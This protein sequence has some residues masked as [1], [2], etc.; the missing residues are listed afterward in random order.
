M[1]KQYYLTGLFLLS[2][3]ILNITFIFTVASGEDDGDG[4]DDDFEEKNKRYIEIN[5]EGNEIGIESIRRSETNK[6][7]ITGLI[8]YDEDGLYI[9]LRYR[10]TLETECELEFG[11]LFHEIIEY[12]DSNSNGIYE[13]EID[14]KINNFSLNDFKPAIHETSDISNGTSLHYIK[15]QTINDTFTAHIYFVEEFTIVERSLIT[16]TQAKIDIEISNFDFTNESSRLALYTKLEF[17]G[18]YDEIEETEDER[19]GYAENENG[20]ITIMSEFTG[21]FSWKNNAT[22]NEVSK[23]VYVNEVFFDEDPKHEQG[24]FI[25]YPNAEHIYHD[26]KIGIENLLI[27]IGKPDSLVSLIIIISVIGAVSASAAY[28][29]NYYVKHRSPTVKLDK[30]REAYFSELF[31]N[32]ID[33]E[34]YDG[35]LA[36]QILRGENAIEKLIKINNINITALSDDF[37]ETINLFEWESH[38]RS[39]FILE[40]LAL[41]PIERNSILE[42]MFKK[43]YRT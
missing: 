42:E 5:I 24:L 10:S 11:I 8:L 20:M 26:P 33:E 39:E 7:E 19:E 30:D 14:Q 41:T 16:P 9:G 34:P 22:I 40:M 38:E 6:D 18:Y 1:K 25:N 23:K 21:F 35:K 17:E 2:I 31:E 36:L 28:S 43:S 12:I 13:P 4:I 29:I 3:L 32:D 37:F 15:I 27:P